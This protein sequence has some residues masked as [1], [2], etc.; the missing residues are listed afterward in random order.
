[1]RDGSLQLAQ[2]AFSG[3]PRDDAGA[4]QLLGGE[5]DAA[6]LSFNRT[7]RIAPDNVSFLR[8]PVWTDVFVGAGV[9]HA[10]V[11]G[12]VGRDGVKNV[13]LSRAPRVSVRGEVV[14]R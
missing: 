2:A 11:A 8:Q 12:V 10:Q 3:N 4:L 9:R 7:G 5:T 6:A 13:L 14:V 1:M